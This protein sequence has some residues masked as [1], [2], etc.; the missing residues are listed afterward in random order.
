MTQP[1]PRYVI[2]HDE[3]QTE[4]AVP[5]SRTVKAMN[6]IEFLARDFPPR[7]N[8]L[9][10]WLGVSSLELMYAWRGMG[11]TLVAHSVAWA[12]ATA[13]GFL[14][15]RAPQPRRVLLIDGEM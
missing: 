11:K 4:S 12:V 2:Y 7:E 10:P 15:W 14:K 13:G 9:T 8:M 6:I 5:V 1:A 3:P